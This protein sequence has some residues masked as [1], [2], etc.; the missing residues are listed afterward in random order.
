MAYA[1]GLDFGTAS[2]RAVIVRQEDGTVIASAG[3]DYHVYTE[4]PATGAALKPQMAL[5][6]PE[7][8]L[9]AMERAV[10]AAMAEAGLT[11][12]DVIAIGTDATSCSL[13]LLGADGQPL[14]TD[15]RWRND[16]HAWIKLWKSH[17]AETEAQDLQRAAVTR[18]EE[19]LQ[20]VGGRVSCEWLLPKSLEIYRESPEVFRAAQTVMDLTDYIPYA[21]TGETTRNMGS[22]AFKAMAVEGEMPS[23]AYMEAAEPGFSALRAKLHGRVIRW[24]D[25]AGSLTAEMAARL[26]LKPGIAVGCGMLDGNAPYVSL[27]MHMDGDLLLTL[28]TSGVLAMQASRA[29]PVKG[30]AGGAMDTFLPGFYGCEAGMSALGDLYN[31]AVKEI[32]PER[33]AALARQAGIS[34]HEAVSPAALDRDPLP[35]DV[36]AL[37]WW[38]GHRGPLPRSDVRGVLVGLSL[39]TRWEDIYRALAESTAF[40]IRLNLENMERQGLRAG[41]IAVCGGIARKNPLLVQLIADALDRPLHFSAKPFEAAAGAAILAVN[42]AE[43]GDARTLE[44]TASR[45]TAPFDRIY[46]PDPARAAA[47]SLRYARYVKLANIMQEFDFPTA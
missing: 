15:E 47:F 33:W 41:R 46:T 11:A 5:A 4:N 28:G 22:W 18:N 43:T 24:G 10:R 27:G 13:V 7:E 42:A 40:C 35:H 8:Y 25:R 17:S 19:F 44:A 34:P 37:D 23:A 1:I 6:D 39:D 45:M 16:P 12:E 30:I 36:M 38:N 2:V 31:W 9:R 26:G 32:L 20:Y 3:C 29:I 21:L 14:C